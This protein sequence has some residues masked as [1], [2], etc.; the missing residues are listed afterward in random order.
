MA[1]QAE[2]AVL[3]VAGIARVRDHLQ[4]PTKLLRIAQ[5]DKFLVEILIGLL[6]T[7]ALFVLRKPTTTAS[8]GNSGMLPINE[9]AWPSEETAL[10]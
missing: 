1:K 8:S 7:E 6:A 2:L 10:L 3:C 4:D 9:P 5:L